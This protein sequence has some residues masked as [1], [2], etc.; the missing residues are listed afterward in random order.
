MGENPKEAFGE[1]AHVNADQNFEVDSDGPVRKDVDE[2]FNSD[3]DFEI[4]PEGDDPR[5]P[6]DL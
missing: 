1:Q 3:Q 6:G 5:E 2:Q 4:N